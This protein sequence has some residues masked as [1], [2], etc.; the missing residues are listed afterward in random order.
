MRR[1]LLITFSFIFSCFLYAQ[2]QPKPYRKPLKE[3]EPGTLTGPPLRLYAD[4]VFDL[5]HFGHAKVCK[6]VY[7]MYLVVR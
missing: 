7:R 4:G 6:S 3:G 5:F 1:K 2:E